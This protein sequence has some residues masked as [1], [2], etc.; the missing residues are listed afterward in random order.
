MLNFV[1]MLRLGNK[2]RYNSIEIAVFIGSKVLE[3][4]VVKKMLQKNNSKNC[5][6]TIFK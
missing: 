2:D 5:F 4:P 1:S 3:R 6:T